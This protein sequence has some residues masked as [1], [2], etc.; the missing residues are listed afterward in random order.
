MNKYTDECI[1]IL[2]DK[3]YNKAERKMSTA[4]RKIADLL[5]AELVKNKPELVDGCYKVKLTGTM[6]KEAKGIE[7]KNSKRASIV[8]IDQL[9]ELSECLGIEGRTIERKT[10]PF[11]VPSEYKGINY[12]EMLVKGFV[13][14]IPKALLEANQ[15]RGYTYQVG[16]YL[17]MRTHMARGAA[18]SVNLETLAEAIFEDLN[19]SK[20]SKN[21]K[22][23]VIN[24]I[25]SALQAYSRI[26]KTEIKIPEITNY[27]QFKETVIEV[28]PTKWQETR[29]KKDKV[30]NLD[31]IKTEKNNSIDN[32]MSAAQ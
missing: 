22:L 12:T 19:D 24:P 15:E 20:R 1:I 28:K 8:T 5:M 6:I 29:S 9:V 31:E 14:K 11:K 3:S 23:L 2:Q 13:C 27:A 26:I 21:R 4:T 7:S 32:E 10:T 25:I 30:I 17:A 18:I 16:K